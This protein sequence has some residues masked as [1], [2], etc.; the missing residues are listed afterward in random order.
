MTDLTPEI[1]HGLR[2]AMLRDKET[3]GN[4]FLPWEPKAV[5]FE[6]QEAFLR[7]PHLTKLAQ[8]GNR[9][10]K[11]TT[12]MRDL[13]WRLMRKHW[14]LD[15]FLAVDDDDYMA[16]GGKIFWLVGPTFDFLKE[17]CWEQYLQ[18][19]IPEWYYTDDDFVSGVVMR[20]EKGVEIIDSVSFRNGDKLVFKTYSQDLKTK[21]GKAVHGVYIDEMPPH[22]NI[23]V[24]L[25]TRT[26]DNDG[27]FILGFTPVVHN[28]EVKEYVDNHKRLHIHRWGLVDNPLFRDNPEKLERALDEWAHLPESMRNMRMTGE[29][30]YESK[31][32]RVFENVDPEIVED[33]EVPDY[34]RRFRVCDPATHRSGYTCY[35]EDPAD[36]Q[37]YCIDAT[38]IEWKGKI[39]KATDI[40]KVLDA[41]VP[42]DGYRF[43]FSLYDNAESWFGSHT[44]GK[45]GKW[46]PCVMKRKEHLL[47]VTREAMV[48]KK[49]KFFKKAAAP[50]IKQIYQ[51]RRKEDG[52]I[53]KKKDHMVDTFQ[54]FCREIP[55]FIPNQV[56]GSTV[57]THEEIHAKHMEALK[58]KWAAVSKT[59]KSLGRQTVSMY[60]R[61]AINSLRGRGLR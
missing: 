57:N 27:C 42:F 17:T 50:L 49:V 36:G 9:A 23:L 12:T 30:Y 22:L 3:R 29:W 51:Y 37:W 32:Q 48:N 31:G 41:R 24:E 38:E 19:F 40:E 6:K 7:D 35:A 2:E 59:S 16:D 11:T 10:A 25:V 52:T 4:A 14:Y 47:M 8:C 5:P 28:E 60:R 1:V 46:R 39:C 43:N 53:H 20:K 26:L 34:W 61:Q 45:C 15:N 44:E 13:S 33:F 58:K 55:K 21:M 18:K 54:Y 56:S